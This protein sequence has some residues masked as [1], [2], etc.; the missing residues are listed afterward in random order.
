MMKSS[1]NS[2]SPGKFEYDEQGEISQYGFHELIE[3]AKSHCGTKSDIVSCPFW[4]SC[5][6]PRTDT[7]VKNHQKFQNFSILSYIEVGNT[8]EE[9]RIRSGETQK[10]VGLVVP[11]EDSSK[12]AGRVGS[13]GEAIGL[14]KLLWDGMLSV[15]LKGSFEIAMEVKSQFLELLPIS[16]PFPS[17]WKSLDF[18]VWSFF[19][20][21]RHKAN[22]P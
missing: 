11:L 2:T 17:P 12:S 15:M 13:Y 6:Q 1:A 14:E 4:Y 18:C 5:S 21:T 3:L 16:F 8:L 22:A 19:L 7:W 9:S 10:S 20:T